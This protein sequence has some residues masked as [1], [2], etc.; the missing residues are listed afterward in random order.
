MLVF[1]ALGSAGAS[2]FTTR[3]ELD[4]ADAAEIAVDALASVGADGLVADEPERGVHVPE[5]EEPV[6]V[7]IVFVDVDGELIETRVQTTVG[8]VVYLDD[9]IGEDDSGRLLTDDEFVQLGNFRDTRLRDARIRTNL[10][11]SVAAAAVTAVGLTLAMR[12]PPSSTPTEE[13]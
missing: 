12:R 10:A 1:L 9:I 5:G 13:P 3:G 11:G 7:W 4:A 6:D 2:W 8:K